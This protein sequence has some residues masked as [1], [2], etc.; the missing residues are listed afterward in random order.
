MLNMFGFLGLCVALTSQEDIIVVSTDTIVLNRDKGKISKVSWLAKK[1][2]QKN[3]RATP[4]KKS[5]T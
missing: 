4:L 3:K 1:K 5:P 2:T